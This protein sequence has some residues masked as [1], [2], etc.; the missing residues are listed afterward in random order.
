MKGVGLSTHAGLDIE[1]KDAA[2]QYLA[3]YDFQS[4]QHGY[5]IAL[6]MVCFLEA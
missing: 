2:L 3:W 1:K 6:G 5:A 4:I